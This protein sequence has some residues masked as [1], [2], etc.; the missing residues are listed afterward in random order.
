[1]QRSLRVAGHPA[2]N[3][4]VGLY[5]RAGGQLTRV[6]RPK[7]R[8]IENMPHHANGLHPFPPVLRG[9]QVIE[10]DS[11]MPGRAGSAEVMRTC[12]RASEFIGPMWT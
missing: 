3:L 6:E 10:P 1:M 11:P 12:P 8:L 4:L 7:G 5:V 2:E 9:G